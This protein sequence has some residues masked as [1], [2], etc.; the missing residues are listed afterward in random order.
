M[1]KLLSKKAREILDLLGEGII[2]KFHRS[3]R[4][5][6]KLLVRNPL[7]WQRFH[8]KTLLYAIHSLHRQ[9]LV[10]IDEDAS[11]TVSIG[12]TQTGK[13]TVRALAAKDALP[14]GWDRKWRLVLFDIPEQKKKLRE[15]FRYQL[16]RMGFV[17]FQR[18]VFLYPYPCVNDIDALT[19]Q[20]GL[21]EHVVMVTAES[22][23]NEFQFK[24]HFGLL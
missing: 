4:G 1:V 10:A 15:A 11:G 21:R 17:E 3:P 7:P 12:L 23:S 22:V 14:Q 18:S 8:R 19:E 9:G 5:Y 13:S 20:T 6:F 16:R 2:L 24:K